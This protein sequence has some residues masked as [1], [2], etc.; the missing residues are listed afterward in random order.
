MIVHMFHAYIVH[1][2]PQFRQNHVRESS[3]M[4]RAS[5]SGA[6]LLLTF[7]PFP[8]TTLPHHETAAI[9]APP[10][11]ALC[12]RRTA[13]TAPPHLGH[14][15]TATAHGRRT[16]IRLYDPSRRERLRSIPSTPCVD[17]DSASTLILYQIGPKSQK[18]TAQHKIGV[19]TKNGFTRV[20]RSERGRP[21]PPPPVHRSLSLGPCVGSGNAPSQRGGNGRC[22]TT[23][24]VYLNL[25]N[26]WYGRD[27]RSGSL[28]RPWVGKADHPRPL[29]LRAALCVAECP[30]PAP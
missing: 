12:R 13:H 7:T 23:Y 3:R 15:Q 22:C 24:L 21:R 10:H 28:P 5:T 18:R 14:L 27:A 4:A 17:Q 2:P 11:S 9:A 29:G 19:A 30:H 8:S 20:A 1:D 6:K 25:R 26:G 16:H